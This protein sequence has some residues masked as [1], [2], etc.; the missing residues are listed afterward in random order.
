MGYGQFTG[1]VESCILISAVGATGTKLVHKRGCDDC[2][3]VRE[4]RLQVTAM[5]LKKVG[6]IHETAGL[7]LQQGDLMG[8]LTCWQKESE[9]DEV[10]LR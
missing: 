10:S 9:E 5:E 2:P 7:K 8:G 1:R 6:H 4:S 3:G